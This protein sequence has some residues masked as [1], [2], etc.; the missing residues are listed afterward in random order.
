VFSVRVSVCVR[1]SMCVF[2]VSKCVCACEYEYVYYIIPIK[3]T[4]SHCAF[5]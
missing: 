4:Y 5:K 3:N 1:V 2:G